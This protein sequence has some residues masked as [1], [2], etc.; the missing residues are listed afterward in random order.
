MILNFLFIFFSDEV[1]M[2]SLIFKSIFFLYI[3]R[4]NSQYKEEKRKALE[5]YLFKQVRAN[6]V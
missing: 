6:S 1:Q 4:A 5:Q 3:L 2:F